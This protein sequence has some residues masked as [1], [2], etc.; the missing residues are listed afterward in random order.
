MKRTSIVFTVL[1][2]IALSAAC[3]KPASELQVIDKRKIE[4]EGA[5]ILTLSPNGNWLAL[6]REHQFCIYQ[7]ETLVE[8]SCVNLGD[9]PRIMQVV[10]DC[11]DKLDK[12]IT[13]TFP[14][15]K[16]QEAF[17]LQLTGQCGKVVLHPWE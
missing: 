6:T 13:H 11:T 1:T 7:V 5:H 16:V 8:Q 9:T 3:G 10:V 2:V 14:M 4:I 12:L 15:N 17:E